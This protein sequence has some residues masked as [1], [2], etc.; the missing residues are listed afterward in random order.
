VPPKHARVEFPTAGAVLLRRIWRDAFPE[1]DVDR[2]LA[3]APLVNKVFQAISY[4]GI[5]RAQEP[6]ARWEMPGIVAATL[7]E[8]AEAY[9]T[10]RWASEQN[11]Y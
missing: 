9:E 10:R 7:R 2:A 6:A 5:Y 1:A 11:A 3:L 8:L 4:E